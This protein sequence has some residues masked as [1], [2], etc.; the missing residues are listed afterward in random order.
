MNPHFG[1]AFADR[2]AIPEMADDGS[3]KSLC[4][5]SQ[6]YSITHPFEPCIELRSTK[7]SIHLSQCILSDTTVQVDSPVDS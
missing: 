6:R 5:T 7:Q 3:V 1:D 4:D 2:F